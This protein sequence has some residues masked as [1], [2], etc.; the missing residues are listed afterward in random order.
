VCV[1]VSDS[2]FSVW[3]ERFKELLG[4]EALRYW[5]ISP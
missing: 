2:A 3:L 1:C 4:Y 5:C